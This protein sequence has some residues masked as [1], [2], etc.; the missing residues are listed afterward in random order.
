VNR[1]VRQYQTTQTDSVNQRRALIARYERALEL[2]TAA[3]AD[4]GAGRE[5]EALERIAGARTALRELAQGLDHSAGGALAHNLCQLYDFC[6]RRLGDAA[7]TRQTRP[8]S[9]V[10]VLLEGLL[11]AWRQPFAKL[12]PGRRP[13]NPQ[14]PERS[15]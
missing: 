12:S 1:A 6:Y 13:I 11:D 7:G 3:E 14:P 9:E 10:A 15:P 5:T 8:L 2:V 4:F